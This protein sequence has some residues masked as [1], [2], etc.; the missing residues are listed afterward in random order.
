MRTL[1]LLVLLLAAAGCDGEPTLQD[2]GPRV[3]VRAERLQERWHNI[4]PQ[5]EPGKNRL[6]VIGGM[7]GCGAEGTVEAGTSANGRDTDLTLR[8][9]PGTTPCQTPY[10]KYTAR[11]SNLP[12]GTYVLYVFHVDSRVM[13]GPVRVR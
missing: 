12:S 10:V 13:A 11:I 4:V 1:L 7:S 3:D 6:T 5:Y 9:M 2:G 8:L